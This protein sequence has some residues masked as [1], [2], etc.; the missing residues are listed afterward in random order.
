VRKEANTHRREAQ[1]LHRVLSSQV[2]VEG[3]AKSTLEANLEAKRVKLHILDAQSEL[4]LPEVCWSVV[5]AMADTRI[6]SHRHLREQRRRRTATSS[7]SCS[8]STG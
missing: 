2:A 7:C 5:N 1:R 6:P 3:D 8:A 4:N